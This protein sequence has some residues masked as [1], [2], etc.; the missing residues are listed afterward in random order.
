MQSR[1][2][3]PVAPKYLVNEV[4]PCLLSGAPVAPIDFHAPE[5]QLITQ[6]KLESEVTSLVVTYVSAVAPAVGN[7]SARHCENDT[8]STSVQPASRHAQ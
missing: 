4:S 3:K 2:G 7:E 1:C 5:H 8:L 6:M